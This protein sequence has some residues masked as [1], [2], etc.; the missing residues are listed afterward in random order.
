MTAIADQPP[1]QPP[2]Q[3]APAEQ[4]ATD[5]QQPTFRTGINFVRVDAIV[6]DRQGAPV[7]DLTQG[8]FEVFEDG[9]PQTLES[10]RLVK[11]DT[12][13]PV[14]TSARP[15]RTRQEEETAAANENARIFVFFLD[16]YHVRLGNS[17]SARKPL[18]EFVRTQ[19]SPND[20]V[21]IMYP[22]TPL[23][24]VVLTRNHESVARA[25]EAF[26]GRKFNYEPRNSI[27]YQYAH[28]PTEVVERLRREVSLSALRGLS[29]KL[30]ALREGRKALILVS[31]GFTYMLPPQMRNADATMPGLGNPNAFNPMAGVNDPNEDRAAWLASLDLDSDLREIFDAANRNNVSIYAVDPR[32]LPGFEFD[33]NENVNTDVSLEELQL[34]TSS[35]SA[36]LTNYRFD[37]GD[38]LAFSASDGFQ[39]VR[40]GIHRGR[41]L[42]KQRVERVHRR[43]AR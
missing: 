8:D 18:A 26:E 22:L 42:F 4:P 13:T 32:G 41:D 7:V 6:T 43:A 15:L 5:V 34:F 40:R 1:P 24:A 2:P 29:I 3:P 19:L 28:Q 27:E 31:E 9:K 35:S 20:L 23:D 38:D 37:D 39:L 12:A 33:I 30:G 21:A 36:T 16:D 17:M 14:E 10:F 25:L 11:I